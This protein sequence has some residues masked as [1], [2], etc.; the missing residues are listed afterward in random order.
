MDPKDRTSARDG[1]PLAKKRDQGA[2]RKQ[3]LGVETKEDRSD[4]NR[5]LSHPSRT[6][7]LQRLSVEEHNAPNAQQTAPNAELTRSYIS[8]SAQLSVR[9]TVFQ[10]DALLKANLET[11][12]GRREPRALAGLIRSSP[13]I[14]LSIGCPCRTF[15]RHRQPLRPELPRRLQ[16]FH[17]KRIVRLDCDSAA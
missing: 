5:K 12:S 1:A 14:V 13:R 7:T 11:T 17:A 10:S 9:T 15:K 3:T 6:E 8:P 4:S 16:A 2:V